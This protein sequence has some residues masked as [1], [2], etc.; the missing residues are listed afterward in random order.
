MALITPTAF[1]KE[2]AE[3]LIVGPNAKGHSPGDP[4]CGAPDPSK[5]AL[6]ANT[7]PSNPTSQ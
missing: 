3:T 7:P 6:K 2:A 1:A 5:G 4:G